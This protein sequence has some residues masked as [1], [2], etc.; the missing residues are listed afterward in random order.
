MIAVALISEVYLKL[1]NHS[2]INSALAVKFVTF[3]ISDAI[4]FMGEKKRS[5]GEKKRVQE[6]TRHILKKNG[7]KGIFLDMKQLRLGDM[8]RTERVSKSTIVSR[9]L[10]KP[11]CLYLRDRGRKRIFL[12]RGWIAI[13]RLSG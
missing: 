2:E 11:N 4:D 13:K 8:K 3:L 1:L 10:A 9:F 12:S 6:N 5:E 7:G